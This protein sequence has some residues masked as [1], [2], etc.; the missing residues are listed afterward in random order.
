MTLVAKFLEALGIACV[1]IGLVQGMMSPS[2]WGELYLAV[3]GIVI[4]Y[5]GRGLEKRASRKREKQAGE[6]TP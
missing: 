6:E 1:M 3:A 5:V 4:F 2:M